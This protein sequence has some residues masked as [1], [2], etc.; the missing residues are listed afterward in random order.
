M[1]LSLHQHI[2]DDIELGIWEIEE[3]E[4]WFL[5]NLHLSP[6]EK[7]HLVLIKGQKRIE[8]LAVRYLVHKMSG[9]AIRGA[10]L[11]DEFG[12]PF[13]Q[14]SPYFISISHSSGRAAVIASPV[15]NGIDIQKIVPKMEL[16]AQ[17]FM[18][19]D[20]L[21]TLQKEHRLTQLHVYWGA[22]EC[23]YK[24]YGRKQLDFRAHIAITPFVFM[25]EGG[26]C[27]G[28][29]KKG[30]INMEFTIFYRLIDDFVLVYSLEKNAKT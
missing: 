27:T 21:N 7:E 23:L 16:I 26:Q 17:K 2:S 28:S 8:W 9:R 13:L 29:V 1:P 10:F 15:N 22:K 14:H 4:S 11:K 6:K 25:P 5:D 18:H 20:E 30:D 12:K 3:S 19:P 24:A